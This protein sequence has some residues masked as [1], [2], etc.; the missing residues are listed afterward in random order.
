MADLDTSDEDVF[1]QQQAQRHFAKGMADHDTN[2]EDG[3]PQ[4]QAQPV[5]YTHL[6]LPT[7]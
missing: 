4:Q 6:T 3:S 5:S 7:N 1:V 2:D